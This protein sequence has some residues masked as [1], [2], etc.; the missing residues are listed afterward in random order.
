MLTDLAVCASRSSST[1]RIRQQS[2]KRTE[3]IPEASQGQSLGRCQYIVCTVTDV[4][5]L[6]FDMEMEQD[7][8]CMSQAALLLTYYAASSN[9][10]R[11]NS[12]WLTH[13]IRFAQIAGADRFH[14]VANTDVKRYTALKRLW[15]GC[16]SRDRIL[17]LGMRRPIQIK[18]T[19]PIAGDDKYLSEADFAD[20][21][22]H[23]RVHDAAAQTRI[24]HV[25]NLACRLADA[26]TPAMTTLFT[27]EKPKDRTMSTSANI[28]TLLADVMN[29]I[30]QLH[31]WHDVAVGIFPPPVALDDEP[32]AVTIYANLL[33]LYYE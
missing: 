13:A 33:F 7:P 18:E 26:L 1:V 27:A 12:L 4:T 25:I 9:K 32:N 17:P 23:S 2:E 5:K 31:A 15:W 11:V 6:L 10:L 24:F 29:H 14:E 8:M 20:E 3:N 30:E 19:V 21:L 22:G 16:L 28:R